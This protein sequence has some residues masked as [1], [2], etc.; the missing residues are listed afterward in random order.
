[1]LTDLFDVLLNIYS[2]CIV[3]ILPNQVVPSPTP[4]FKT[5]KIFRHKNLFSF[6]KNEEFF[7]DMEGKNVIYVNR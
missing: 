1:M 5:T 6:K 7:W 4:G 2:L 3:N